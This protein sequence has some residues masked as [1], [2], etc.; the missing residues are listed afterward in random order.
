MILMVTADHGPAVS[1]AHN[2]IV[3]ARAGKDLISS[4]V[5][6]MLTIGPRFGG[7]LDEAARVFAAAHDERIVTAGLCFKDAKGKEAHH[8]HWAQS[9]KSAKSGQACD[10]HQELC[11]AAFPL[12]QRA[13][14][15]ARS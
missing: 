7:A 13:E 4:L 9:K 5:S 1:G 11:T 3:T 15:C 10:D 12:E 8:G 6:R 14:L 2:T